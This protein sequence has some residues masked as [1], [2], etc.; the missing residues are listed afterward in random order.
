VDPLF[1]QRLVGTLVLVAL[2]IV[3]W[4]LIFVT[5]ETRE[6]IV[7]QPMSQRPAVDQTPIP[8]PES[9]ESSVAPKLPEPPKNS[10]PAQ[11]AADI[12][13]QTDA[14]SGSLAAL[15]D[16]ESL[17]APQPRVAPPSE[18]PLV[19]DQGLAIFYVLQVATVG[20]ASRADELVEGLQARGYKAYSSR[21][22]QVDDELFRVQIGPNA[23]RAPLVR[24]KPEIDTVL[25]V[26][27]QILRYEQ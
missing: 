17:A 9:F 15:P 27:S 26:D 3:F 8:E 25:K 7:L 16:S 22:V 6:P 18:A 20:S 5:P 1:R 23:E 19:D 2:G 10:T 14:E 12:Q 4:P 11:E 13:T 21:Y 24:L